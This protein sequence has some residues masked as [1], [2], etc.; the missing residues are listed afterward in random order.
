M[1]QDRGT[2]PLRGISRRGGELLWM[3]IVSSSFRARVSCVLE[4]SGPFFRTR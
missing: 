1:C 3:I 4:N 2:I